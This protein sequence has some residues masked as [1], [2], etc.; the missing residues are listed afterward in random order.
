MSLPT[1]WTRKSPSFEGDSQVSEGDQE[2][3]DRL[4][5]FRLVAKLAAVVLVVVLPHD[6]WPLV[7][8]S[9][10]CKGG[11]TYEGGPSDSVRR[12]PALLE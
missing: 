7:E 9:L 6:L 10:V 8:G 3:R 2:Q 4:E 5:L 1:R 11:Y 12:V